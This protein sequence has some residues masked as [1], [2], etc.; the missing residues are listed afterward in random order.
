MDPKAL[1]A[2]LTSARV[3]LVDGEPYMRKVVRAMLLGMGVRAVHEADDGPAM[4]RTHCPDVVILDWEMPGL[5]GTSFVRMVRSPET[6]PL[7]DTPII[8]LTGH[9]EKQRVMEA[10]CIGVNEFLLKPVSTNALRDRLVFVL[11]NPR[12]MVSSG[13]YYG[14]MPRKF[15]T[16]LHT[17]VHADNDQAVAKVFMLN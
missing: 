16:A 5:N 1:T 4:I 3:L 13:P 2:K 17:N 14:P 7:P 6:F 10:V 11:V 15:A 9:G 12:K 8:M